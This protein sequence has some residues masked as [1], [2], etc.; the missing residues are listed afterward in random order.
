MGLFRKREKVAEPAAKITI[1]EFRG[2]PAARQLRECLLARDWTNA[3]E[4][5]SNPVSPE[6]FSRHIVIAANTPGVEEWIDTA[7][8]RDPQSILPLLVRGARFVYWAWEARGTGLANTVGQDTWKVWFNR[9]KQAE[10]SLDEVVERDSRCVEGWH[11]LIVLGRAR[12]V[13]SEERWRRFNGLIAV[14]P[15]HFPGNSQ[16]LEGLKKKWSG[17][18]EEMFSFAR[19]RAAAAPG[20]MLPVLVAEAH[21]EYRF[22]NGGN[23]YMERPDVGDEL[24]AVA[25]Q[26]L[27]HPNYQRTVLTPVLLNNFAYAFAMADRFAEAERC[28]AEIGDDLVTDGPWP[29]SNGSGFLRLRAYVRHNLA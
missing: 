15:F 16:M 10:D 3:R 22:D 6:H 9:L 13:D 18:H 8:A 23:E 25:H 7:I 5:L 19:E 14:D 11:W 2:D 26:S 4:I 1:D 20:T 27:W 24:V 21:L 29:G 17:S 12:Q 28:F